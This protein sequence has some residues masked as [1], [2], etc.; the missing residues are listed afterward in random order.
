M[1]NLSSACCKSSAR[2]WIMRTAVNLGC[3]AATQKTFVLCCTAIAFSADLVMH[4]V[5]FLVSIA[6]KDRQTHKPAFMK[7]NNQRVNQVWEWNRNPVEPFTP[8]HSRL[9]WFMKR[10][11]ENK[12]Y[13][14]ETEISSST[15]VL[16]ESKD[17]LNEWP[18][19]NSANDT[20]Q[21]VL[22]RDSVKSDF[23]RRL[24]GFL[25][26]WCRS[27]RVQGALVHDHEAWELGI[28]LNLIRCL[29]PLQKALTTISLKIL[30][31]FNNLPDGLEKSLFDDA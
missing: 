25:R 17:N 6:S 13:L 18:L 22:A 27:R 12:K 24:G 30:S 15:L 8:T 9:F 5:M 19:C 31:C 7:S 3:K 29:G 1:L 26:G 10:N 4:G 28:F 20:I 16:K 11:S 2:I 14:N 21:F 23:H